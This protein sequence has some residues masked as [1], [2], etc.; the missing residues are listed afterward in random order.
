MSQ[1]PP[2]TLEIQNDMATDP[3]RRRKQNQDAIGQF[4]PP[5]AGV[6]ATLG[7]IFVLADGVGGLEGGDLASQYAVSTII[8]SYYEQEEGEPSERLARAIA[9]ANNVIYAEGHEHET[10][11]VM[12]TTVVVAVVIGNELVI[13]SV[14]DS[15]AY[16][17]RDA[18]AR[19][20]T[21]DHTLG[22]MRREAG[23]PLS[24][25]DP[26]SG[27]L[28][29][30]LGSM[31]SVKVDIITGRVRHGDHVVLC[32]DGL[33]RY[34]EPGEIETT[35]ATLP[36]GKTAQ[37]LVDMANERGGVDNI[38][39]IVLRMLGPDATTPLTAI[40]VEALDALAEEDTG[41]PDGPPAPPIPDRPTSAQREAFAQPTEARSLL[42]DT[43][44]FL[45]GNTVITGIGMAVLLVAFAALLI[46]VGDWG[47]ED[48]EAD[49]PAI[50]PTTEVPASQRTQTAEGVYAATQRAIA[51]QTND[52]IQA[53]TAAEIARRT[54][55]PPTPIA[56]SGPQM[57]EG[58]WFRVLA[59]EAI[60]AYSEPDRDSDA[61]EALEEDATFRVTD[62]ER[63]PEG[64]PWYRVI[65][66]FG[67]QGRWVAGPDL[68]A[69]ITAVN[70]TGNPLPPDQQPLDVPPPDGTDSTPAT[71]TPRLTPT[72]PPTVPGTPGT[73]ATPL[74]S[75][76]PT[77]TV[78]YGVES[79]TAGDMVAMKTT[80]D[81]CRTTSVLYCD[82][83][84]ATTDEIGTVVDGPVEA[85]GHWWWEIEF[86]DGRRG[87][88]AQALLRAP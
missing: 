42:T 55:T 7:Q 70:T 74:P 41:A 10:R 85:E 44:A 79:W 59:G 77:P 76:S 72:P 13:G 28:V 66:A 67:I 25:G 37:A 48:N 34:V 36:I 18:Q 26:S 24:A 5:D 14:G 82:A 32:S 43:W 30:A 39:V 8:R 68:H 54:L 62:V 50:P 3:G 64:G 21:L 20:L 17:M 49:S 27:K 45:R 60:P 81:L 86:S 75:P 71:P 40:D 38:S 2:V 53:A 65:D 61:L 57:E 88:I 22:N 46:V 63:A 23:K 31:P 16:L 35:I 51:V 73:P 1:S 19:Q 4:T 84:Q 12:A 52:A 15:P 9:E 56:T 29:R 6:L 58:T 33:T 47:D 83:G 78:A 87:W 69:R 11:G 80:L